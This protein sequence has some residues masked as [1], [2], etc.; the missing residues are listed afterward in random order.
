[1]S[2]PSALRLSAPLSLA[3][4]RTGRQAGIPSRAV[5]AAGRARFVSFRFASPVALSI[6]LAGGR[7][8]AAFRTRAER[9]VHSR[10]V[11]STSTYTHMLVDSYRIRTSAARLRLECA[12]GCRLLVSYEYI[13]SSSVCIQQYSTVRLLG[14]MHL[15]ASVSGTGFLSKRMWLRQRAEEIEP[16]RAEKRGGERG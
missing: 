10:T 4:R 3:S 2:P 15:R 1:M 12:A 6:V 16:S 13:Y 11:T 9:N 8:R 5:A 7:A 14:C